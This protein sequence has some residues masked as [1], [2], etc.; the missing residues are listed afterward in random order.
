[1]SKTG[2]VLWL[3][4]ALFICWVATTQKC[5]AQV[6][7][8]RQPMSQLKYEDNGKKSEA[9]EWHCSGGTYE[10]AFALLS[11]GQVGP[12][13][14]MTISKLATYTNRGGIRETL[15]KGAELVSLAIG[16][17]AGLQ[18]TQ[19]W[20]RSALGGAPL[21]VQG[22]KNIAGG[23]PI[24]FEQTPSGGGFQ[25]IYSMTSGLNRI[26]ETSALG[27]PKAQGASLVFKPTIWY[28]ALRDNGRDRTLREWAIANYYWTL[29]EKIQE[30]QQG[31]N[32]AEK[33]T[34]LALR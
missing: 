27:A 29:E 2:W 12:F 24:D 1:M 9:S 10:R 32:E 17:L 5:S 30:A 3:A 11:Q 15:F 19:V 21:A 18:I 16:P 4:L 31:M 28:V 34:L 6:V 22:I 8:D 7:C 13:T 14:P 33:E 25:V 26:A 20:L 23:V